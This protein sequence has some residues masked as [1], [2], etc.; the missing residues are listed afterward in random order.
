MPRGVE[1]LPGTHA[2]HCHAVE[3]WARCM[4]SA[5][6]QVAREQERRAPGK[7]FSRARPVWGQRGAGVQLECEP[8]VG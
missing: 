6:A 2:G 1:V 4:Q 8:N 7:D 3:V 5:V